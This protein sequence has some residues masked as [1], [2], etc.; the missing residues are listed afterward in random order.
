[1][2][3]ETS[4][5]DRNVYAIEATFYAGINQ[6]SILAKKN[7]RQVLLKDLP[8]SERKKIE[9]LAAQAYLII[10]EKNTEIDSN[11]AKKQNKK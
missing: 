4:H 10:Q 2:Q 6:L 7:G 3:N 8:E 11:N 5:K 9:A 1:M